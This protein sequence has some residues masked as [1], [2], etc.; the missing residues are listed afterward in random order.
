M[1][2]HCVVWRQSKKKN[3]P[4]FVSD[5]LCRVMYTNYQLFELGKQIERVME[6]LQLWIRPPVI[7]C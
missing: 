7:L 3:V 2:S 4:A 1:L 6:R 5:V